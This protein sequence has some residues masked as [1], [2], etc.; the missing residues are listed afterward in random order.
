MYF[1]TENYLR[2]FYLKNKV[3]IDKVDCL[4]TLNLSYREKRNLMCLIRSYNVRGKEAI[5][6]INSFPPKT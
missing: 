3:T 4:I 6:N 5:K 1:N 2:G